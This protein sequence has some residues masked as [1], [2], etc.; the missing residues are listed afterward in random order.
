MAP[1][2]RVQPAEVGQ[3]CGQA[4]GEPC[5]L[6]DL[7]ACQQVLL[8]LMVLALFQEE[9]RGLRLSITYGIHI[10]CIMGRRA[11]L[12]YPRVDRVRYPPGVLR[13][14]A[15]K[16]AVAPEEV[17]AALL[18][19]SATARRV[20]DRRYQVLGRTEAGRYL[21]IFFDLEPDH[22]SVVVSAREMTESERLYYRRRAK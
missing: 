14:L 12:D 21:V 17:R 22:T 2:R 13:K 10:Y 19:P 11:L 1:H 15:E 7:E 5:G 3:Y 18:D 4:A 8:G 16:H 20:G 6:S 9:P